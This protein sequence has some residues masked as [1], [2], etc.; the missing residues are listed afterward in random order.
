MDRPEN[1]M[2]RGET[3]MRSDETTFQSVS[4][5]EN[6]SSTSINLT[7]KTTTRKNFYDNNKG[8]LP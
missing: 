4:N 2:G 1:K 5:V 6:T 7:T 8:S 3:T